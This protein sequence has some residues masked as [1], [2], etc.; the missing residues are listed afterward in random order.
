MKLS[1]TTGVIV[2]LHEALSDTSKL[3]NTLYVGN[4]LEF[5]L[6]TIGSASS[7]TAMIRLSGTWIEGTPD[8]H[9]KK[10]ACHFSFIS[11]ISSLN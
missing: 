5:K 1:T 11:S 10:P 6:S 2:D 9:S 3:T 7:N 4:L 8:T